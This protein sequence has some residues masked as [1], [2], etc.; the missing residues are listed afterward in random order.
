MEYGFNSKV[1][2]TNFTINLL[3]SPLLMNH[4]DSNKRN[5]IN[6]QNYPDYRAYKDEATSVFNDIYFKN[7]HQLQLFTHYCY[8]QINYDIISNINNELNKNQEVIKYDEE[9]LLVFKGGNVVKLYTDHIN[10]KLGNDD[11]IKASDTDF[12]IYIINDDE[13]KFNLIYNYVS[14]LLYK[15]LI[16][17]R[18]YF[19]KMFLDTFYPINVNTNRKFNNNNLYLVFDNM[20]LD[21]IYSI[22]ETILC[23]LNNYSMN[24]NPYYLTIIFNI[25]KKYFIND[26][27]IIVYNDIHIG[28]KYIKIL[29]SISYYLIDIDIDIRNI[30]K[31]M[32]NID[33]II[34]TQRSIIEKELNNLVNKLSGFYNEY[35]KNA[36]LNNLGTS[37]KGDNFLGKSYY[38]Y[39]ETKPLG[40]FIVN[41]ENIELKY[42]KRCDMIFKD[43]QDIRFSQFIYDDNKNHHYI[44]INSTI[45]CIYDNYN[46]MF[47]LFRIKLNINLQNITEENDTKRNNLLIP[48][49]FLDISIPKYYDTGLINLRDKIIKTCNDG[50]R[51]L[52]SKCFA[53]LSFIKDNYQYKNILMYNISYLVKDL[54]VML[55]GQNFMPWINNKYNK[56]LNRFIFLSLILFYKNNFLNNGTGNVLGNLLDKIQKNLVNLFSSLFKYYNKKYPTLINQTKKNYYRTNIA[57]S[58]NNIILLKDEINSIIGN[59]IYTNE[60]LNPD[61]IENFYDITNKTFFK[62]RYEDNNLNKNNGKGNGNNKSNISNISNVM[63]I[64]GNELDE[65]FNFI[66][67]LINFEINDINDNIFNKYI[68]LKFK[69]FKYIFENSQED[70][71]LNNKI[72]IDLLDFLFKFNELFAVNYNMFKQ[73]TNKNYRNVSIGNL[74]GGK[75]YLKIRNNNN[76]SIKENEKKIEEKLLNI[77]LSLD[78]KNNPKSNNYHKSNSELIK[79]I[80]KNLK[81]KISSMDSKYMLKINKNSVSLGSSII[82]DFNNNVNLNI[83]SNVKLSSKPLNSI[84]KPTKLNILDEDTLNYITGSSI[85]NK[86]IKNN[87]D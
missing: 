74:T 26:D 15:S 46:L 50:E 86:Q 37:L 17:I 78:N 60:L 23:Y 24:N 57:R 47:D 33:N 36:L 80:E 83:N 63:D 25:I 18:D 42:E 32:D 59:F 81:I 38:K 21:V 70:D 22:D 85:Y 61:I 10:E 77:K 4:I 40:T 16:K 55:F 27:K 48:S 45:F 9:I 54:N 72:R 11:D 69:S 13:K 28:T 67:K 64:F 2:T 31:F 82:E 56:R 1:N 87:S 43:I 19:E 51:N 62:I 49:E 6:E 14:V 5:F 34:L 75:G 68:K 12:S 58:T 8:Q 44:S 29:H 20:D 53:K 30:K 65:F 7:E 71:Y 73:H 39:Y 84:K 79:K 41:N 3:D 52:Y 35:K 66:F 76:K